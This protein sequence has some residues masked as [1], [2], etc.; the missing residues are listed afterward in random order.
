M[1]WNLSLDERKECPTD[2]FPDPCPKL[3][4]MGSVTILSCETLL[5]TLSSGWQHTYS[6]HVYSE[7]TSICA[8][9][10]LG[11]NQAQMEILLVG[12]MWIGPGRLH[13]Y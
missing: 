8:F 11:F 2:C 13:L 3:E 9:H 4:M 10:I 12:T 6:I 7:E 1:A 5:W